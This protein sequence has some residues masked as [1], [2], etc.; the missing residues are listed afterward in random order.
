MGKW[1]RRRRGRTSSY[2]DAR[3]PLRCVRSTSTIIESTLLVVGADGARVAS[4][5]SLCTQRSLNKNGEARPR[6]LALEASLGSR[7]SNVVPSMPLAATASWTASSPA[8]R[9]AHSP[10]SC[11]LHSLT[12]RAAGM[13]AMSSS[14]RARRALPWA[15]RPFSFDSCVALY[16]Y[17]TNHLTN[18]LTMPPMCKP[19]GQRGGAKTYP[20]SAAEVAN[21]TSTNALMGCWAVDERLMYTAL[22]KT[23]GASETEQVTDG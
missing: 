3:K 12:K 5:S 10:T 14:R 11:G 7:Q 20:S 4:S 2:S 21:E 1:N 18:H 13:M 15:M 19:H 8:V 22:S 23:K 9:P 17:T 6:R 16:L